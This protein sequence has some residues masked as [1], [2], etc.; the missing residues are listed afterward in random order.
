MP[1]DWTHIIACAIN[2]FSYLARVQ[3]H[4]LMWST[5][6]P[7]T[8]SAS[9][10]HPTKLDQPADLPDLVEGIDRALEEQQDADERGRGEADTGI[11]ISDVGE[12][13]LQQ[14]HR[15]SPLGNPGEPTGL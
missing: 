10:A 3:L 15:S 1:R 7:V 14:L 4:S 9:C 5:I 11:P 8:R 2:M 6:A 12:E 13:G